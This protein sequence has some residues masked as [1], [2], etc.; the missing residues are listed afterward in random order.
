MTRLRLDS[1]L[2]EQKFKHSFQD[3]I[4]PLTVVTKLNVQFI[5]CCPLFT[6]QKSTLYSTLR[7]L[8]SKLFDSTDS[9]LTNIL[10]FGDMEL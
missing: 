1:H 10:L 7:S 4:N 8:D 9:L 2:R 6:N 5:S 3:S